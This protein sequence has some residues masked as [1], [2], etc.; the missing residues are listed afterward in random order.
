MYVN[1]DAHSSS[2]GVESPVAYATSSELRYVEQA[3][4]ARIRENTPLTRSLQENVEQRS[5]TASGIDEPQMY[6]TALSLNGHNPP[7]AEIPMYE[8]PRDS[9]IRFQQSHE[10]D[11]TEQQPYEVPIRTSFREDQALVLSTSMSGHDTNLR[12]S[13]SPCHKTASEPQSSSPTNRILSSSVHDAQSPYAEPVT[14]AANN[15]PNESHLYFVLDK[16]QP[17]QQQENDEEPFYFELENRQQGTEPAESKASENLYAEVDKK[18]ANENERD[19]SDS[20]SS[21]SDMSEERRQEEVDSEPD[22]HPYF[23]IEKK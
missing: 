13:I 5:S 18:D 4:I 6:E 10:A 1:P 7:E 11:V 20:E 9:I 14:T 8:E 15:S 22:E 21:G 23:I 2:N 17:E 3:D 19:Q 12:N 16:R